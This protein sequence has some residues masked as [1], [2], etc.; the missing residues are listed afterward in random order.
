MVVCVDV[1]KAGAPTMLHLASNIIEELYG[2]N[3]SPGRNVLLYSGGCDST[4]ILH[5]LLDAYPEKEVYTVAIRYPWLLKEK[6]ESE[7]K[8]RYN[9]I[10]HLTERGCKIDHSEFDVTQT[11]FDFLANDEDDKGLSAVAG[12]S[13]QAVAWLSLIS[14]Y[15]SRGDK[16]YYGILGSD[17]N[18]RY[19]DYY[20]EG[21]KYI[22]YTLDR[23]GEVELR[24]PLHHKTKDYV[25]RQLLIRDIYKY[26]WYCETPE[27]VRTPCH[28]CHPCQ[29]HL[30][31]LAGIEQFDDDPK[32]RDK[33][34]EI[35][36]PIREEL[37]NR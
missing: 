36:D 23:D 10:K 35:L 32:L 26:T 21:M 31:T 5:S 9:Y 14:I 3:D 13:P 29:T 12:G 4:L 34:K 20:R 1:V 6:Y 19:I 24:T 22:L 25:L 16:L 18:A 37:K 28:C 30:K 33:A 8:T 2:F 7:R 15:L 17:S 11:G 27:E